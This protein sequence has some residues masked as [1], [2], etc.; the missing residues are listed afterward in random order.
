METTW[1]APM[2]YDDSPAENGTA[3]GNVEQLKLANQVVLGVTLGLTMV[4]MGAAIEPSDFKVVL[5]R[6]VGVAIGFVCQ[7]VLMPLLG[8]T[9]ALALRLSAPQALGALITASSPGGTTSN[10]FTFWTDGDVCLS[11]VMTT[12]STVVTFGSM[13]LNLFIYGRRWTSDGAV[14]PYKNILIALASLVGPV[15]VGMLIRWKSKEWAKRIGTPF[16]AIGMMGIATSVVLT[17][18][19]NPAIFSSSWK[20]FFAP[21]AHMWTGWALGYIFARLCRQPHKQSRTIAF[22]TGLQQV[23]IALTLI[24][25]SYKGDHE[26]FIGVIVYPMIFGPFSIISFSSFTLAYQLYRRFKPEENVAGSEHN[27]DYDEL[28]QRQIEN[29]EKRRPSKDCDSSNEKS[30]NQV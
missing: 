8:F 27:M 24:T 3:N 23:G 18:L 15:I 1:T 6:P 28:P 11:V 20:L 14:I 5:R 22:E 12:I 25:F 13:P 26:L 16:G 7:V 4:A 30:E 21:L 29:G 10:L 19:I 9:M 2:L 17:I